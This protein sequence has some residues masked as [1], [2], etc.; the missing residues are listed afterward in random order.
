MEKTIQAKVKVEED[1][2]IEGMFRATL[3]RLGEDGENWVHMASYANLPDSEVYTRFGIKVARKP[4]PEGAK[5]LLAERLS[6]LDKA[7]YSKSELQDI[8]V[9]IRT[10]LEGLSGEDG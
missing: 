4:D 6:S 2:E 3:S 10:Q 8:L 5:D 7:S 1:E 9:D